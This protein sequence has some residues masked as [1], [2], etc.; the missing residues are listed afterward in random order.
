MNLK[1]VF[2]NKKKWAFVARWDSRTLTM[3]VAAL[4]METWEPPSQ[5]KVQFMWSSQGSH[6][7]PTTGTDTHNGSEDPRGARRNFPP[8]LVK[9]WGTAIWT[10]TTVRSKG[11]GL[12]CH[13]PGLATHIP[14]SSKH[15]HE[16]LH[17]VLH[18][19]AQIHADCVALCSCY[20]TDSSSYS[21]PAESKVFM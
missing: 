3:M 9:V 13:A 5:C 1:I 15:R 16:W 18:P 8:A 19:Q 14:L 6:W 11:S 20:I 17:I 21:R 10:K 7:L 12:L 4:D 2:S